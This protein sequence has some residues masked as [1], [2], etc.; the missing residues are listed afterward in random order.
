MSV[1]HQLF[2]AKP[3]AHLRFGA[4]ESIGAMA[5][6]ST[7]IL[8]DILELQLGSRKLTFDLHEQS[9]LECCSAQHR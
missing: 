3:E 4:A 7:D 1:H 8:I 2:F 5:N 9:Y 6:I